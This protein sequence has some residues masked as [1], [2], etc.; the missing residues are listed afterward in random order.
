MSG[1]VSL[2]ESFAEFRL[3]MLSQSPCEAPFPARQWSQG[4]SWGCGR[5]WGHRCEHLNI[6]YKRGHPPC[7]FVHFLLKSL[8]EHRPWMKLSRGHTMEEIRD[9]S[10]LRRQ[11]RALQYPVPR[12]A[13]H[14]QHHG[15]DCRIGFCFVCRPL[16]PAGS[17]KPH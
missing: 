1:N 6:G 16:S 3:D 9:W 15:N 5:G 8:F 14:A 11:T 2:P 10:R 7:G 17:V 13:L 4:F 12:I